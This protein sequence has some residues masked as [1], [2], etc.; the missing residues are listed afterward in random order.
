MK[1]FPL[2]LFLFCCCFF[3]KSYAYYETVYPRPLENFSGLSV[4]EILSK[5]KAAVQS[6]KYFGELDYSPSYQVFQIEDHLPWISAHEI[7]CNGLSKSR[8]ISKGPSRES[9]GILNPELLYY[10]NI[11]TIPIRVNDAPCSSEDYFIPYDIQLDK[12]DKKITARINYSAFYNKNG[13]GSRLILSDSN[14]RDFGYNYAYADYNPNLRF[15]SNYNISTGLITTRGFYHRGG[16]CRLPS[17]CNNYSPYNKAIEFYVLETPATLR[18][19]L[20]KKAPISISEPADI[21]YIME[22]E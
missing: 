18:I 16:S 20:W 8:D 4:Q 5:R 1:I 22:F 12:F 6:S 3:N 13:A 10:V 17:G 11:S 2:I 21:T 14:A 19:K 15:S 9:V 7:S